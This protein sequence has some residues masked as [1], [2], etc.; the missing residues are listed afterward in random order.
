MVVG[1][2]LL[3]AIVAAT[4]GSMVFIFGGSFLTALMVYLATGLITIL[5]ILLRM[6][7]MDMKRNASKAGGPLTCKPA[8][9]GA[10]SR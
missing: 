1:L 9:T 2:V 8:E 10:T 6:V 7:L 4:C 3:S 5:S